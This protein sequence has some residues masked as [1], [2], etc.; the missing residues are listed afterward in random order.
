MC[1]CV[2]YLATWH[3]GDLP[4]ELGLL[5]LC[6]GKGGDDDQAALALA[7]SAIKKA[8]DADALIV[9]VHNPSERDIAARLRAGVR[10]ERAYLARLDETPVAP[11]RL[12]P[13]CGCE[14]PVDVK[15][16]QIVTL[17]LVRGDALSPLA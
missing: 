9:R 8:E 10:L 4:S 15:P 3:E 1:P 14:L 16:K 5:R 13:G 11:V 17:V 2:A 6:G 7:V 12:E